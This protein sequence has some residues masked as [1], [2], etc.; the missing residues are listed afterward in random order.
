MTCQTSKKILGLPLDTFLCENGV[1]RFKIRVF[2]VHSTRSERRLSIGPRKGST[3]REICIGPVVTIAHAPQTHRATFRLSK[4]STNT[5]Y[6]K[7]YFAERRSVCLVVEKEAGGSAIEIQHDKNICGKIAL[8]DGQRKT[9]VMS[10]F[11]VRCF[12][13]SP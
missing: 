3:P 13:C 4:C 8:N 11:S 10:D 12:C 2:L 6:I 7:P 9:F 1:F 5:S